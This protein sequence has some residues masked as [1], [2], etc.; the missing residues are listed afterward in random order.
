M[1][2]AWRDRMISRGRRRCRQGLGMEPLEDRQ[3]P[4]GPGIGSPLKLVRAGPT[5][6]FDRPPGQVFSQQSGSIDITLSRSSGGGEATLNVHTFTPDYSGSPPSPAPRTPPA[7]PG[8][9]YVPI[10]Q[11]VV[12][13]R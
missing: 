9:Q 7:V 5:F 2:N 11:T 12:F 3:L 8:E 10:H 4:S 6:L 13:H 1:A